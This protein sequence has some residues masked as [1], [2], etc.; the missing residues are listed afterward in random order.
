MGEIESLYE[1]KTAQNKIFYIKTL[2]NMKFKNEPSV[3]DHLSLFQD[4]VN[5][6][7]TMKI[8]LDEEL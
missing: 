1:H 5:N 2:I 7:F 8:I 6:L 4:Y 3:S